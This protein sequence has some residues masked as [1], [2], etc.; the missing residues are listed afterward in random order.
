MNAYRF[1]IPRAVIGF[2]ALTMTALTLALSVVVPAALASQRDQSPAL[3]AVTNASNHAAESF[4][5]IRVEVVGVRERATAF[6]PA[7]RTL[8]KHDK[9]EV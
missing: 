7:P 1:A 8:P 9:Q 5:L 4:D 3:R 2:A 6:V